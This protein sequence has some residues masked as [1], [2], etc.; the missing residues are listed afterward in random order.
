MRC[1]LERSP[2][3]YPPPDVPARWLTAQPALGGLRRTSRPALRGDARSLPRAEVRE[4]QELLQPD[5][6]GE[7]NRRQIVLIHL[8]SRDQLAALQFGQR[9]SH[10]ASGEA[11]ATMWRRRHDAADLPDLPMVLEGNASRARF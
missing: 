2:P 11:L 4:L 6:R 8:I 5:R 10:H 3:A 1:R 9:R 7:T